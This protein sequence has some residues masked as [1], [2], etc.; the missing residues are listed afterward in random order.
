MTPTGDHPPYPSFGAPAVATHGVDPASGPTAPLVVLL[1]DR[2]TPVHK[3][4]T[5]HPSAVL[6]RGGR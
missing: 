1:L 4:L 2:G 3:R 5:P 6:A